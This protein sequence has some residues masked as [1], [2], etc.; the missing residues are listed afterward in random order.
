MAAV[1]MA[2]VANRP[3][4]KQRPWGDKLAHLV[5]LRDN[6]H[7]RRHQR[8]RYHAVD[9]CAPEQRPDRIERRVI[10]REA[11]QRGQADHGVKAHGLTR[12]PQPGLPAPGLAHRIGGRAGKDGHGKQAGA[13]DADAEQHEGQFPAI[14]SSATAASADVWI[15]V[16]PAPC[17]VVAVVR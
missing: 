10:D 6:D 11:Q 7:H 2:A 16:R 9:H 17:S 1:P 15:S 14:S 8:D 12:L 3:E 5:L 13:D 4:R